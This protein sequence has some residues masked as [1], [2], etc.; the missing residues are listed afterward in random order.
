M[1]LKP[2]KCNFMCLRSILSVDEIFTFKNVKLKNTS[3]NQT[4]GVIIERR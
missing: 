1:T 2:G 3:V 4:L